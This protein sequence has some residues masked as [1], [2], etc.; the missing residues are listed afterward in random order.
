MICVTICHDAVCACSCKYVVDFVWLPCWSFWSHWS[1][2]THPGHS[3]SGSGDNMGAIAEKLG[4]ACSPMWEH[5]CPKSVNITRVVIKRLQQK[6]RLAMCDI[7][8]MCVSDCICTV[9]LSA[10]PPLLY[11]IVSVKE[12]I[13]FEQCLSCIDT[14]TFWHHVRGNYSGSLPW[15]H[16]IQACHVV[17]H[18]CANRSHA[19][20]DTMSPD[21]CSA[22]FW[23]PLWHLIVWPPAPLS[24]ES[25]AVT[26]GR[27]D[28]E[29]EKEGDGL[30]TF[31]R[32]AENKEAPQTH[33]S[34]STKW[35]VKRQYLYVW[36]CIKGLNKS[37]AVSA[38]RLT[39]PKTC[40]RKALLAEEDLNQ[41]INRAKFDR[42]IKLV[43]SSYD[44]LKKKQLRRKDTLQ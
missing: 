18:V 22:F 19:L 26:G 23:H 11:Q 8:S 43:N 21:I 3:V 14:L 1:M 6:Q 28:K 20:C 24:R 13:G 12:G 16:V 32:Q 25:V 35:Q 9:H 41:K 5:T 17:W 10:A 2:S 27:A 33:K 37:Q 31:A 44:S 36:K 30:E 42:L 4:P 34:Q 7:H 39:N 15:L 38:T 29:E 40:H